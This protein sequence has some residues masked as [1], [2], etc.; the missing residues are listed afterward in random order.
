[1]SQ[2]PRYQDGATCLAQHAIDI[3]SEQRQQSKSR[4]V[5][6]ETDQIDLIPVSVVQDFTIGLTFGDRS[7]D[8]APEMSFGW[9]GLLQ[10]PRGFVIGPLV[11]NRIPGEFRLVQSKWWEHVQ[12]MQL[13]LILLSKL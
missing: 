4:A 3:R 9:H 5:R 8:V 7:L 10:A 13:R 11:R 12:Q 1:M 2:R 6:A